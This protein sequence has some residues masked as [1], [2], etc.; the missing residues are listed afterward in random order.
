MRRGVRGPRHLSTAPSMMNTWGVQDGFW[1]LQK[2]PDCARW[3]VRI[4]AG[5]SGADRQLSPQPLTTYGCASIGR[6]YL[7][8]STGGASTGRVSPVRSSPSARLQLTSFAVIPIRPP[9][10]IGAAQA[11]YGMA[12]NRRECDHDGLAV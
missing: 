1:G 2:E 10:S 5:R 12:A 11:A 6:K 8:W 7:D 3:P 4:S 9:P